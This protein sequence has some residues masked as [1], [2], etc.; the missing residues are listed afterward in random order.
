MMKQ[1]LSQLLLF[2]S[3]IGYEVALA[4]AK[5]AFDCTCNTGKKQQEQGK[6]ANRNFF[7]QKSSVQKDDCDLA[8]PNDVDETGLIAI[9]RDLLAIGSGFRVSLTTI[10]EAEGYSF[11]VPI[12]KPFIKIGTAVSNFVLIL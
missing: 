4:T 8:D 1:K 7:G 11:A 10:K 5:A 6:H 3:L 2:Y 12:V 9:E